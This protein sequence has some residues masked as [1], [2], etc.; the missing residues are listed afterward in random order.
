MFAALAPDYNIEFAR[1]VAAGLTRPRKT[2]SASW[3]YDALGSSLFEAITLLPEYGLT[4]A[5]G[6]LLARH[7][8]EIVKAANSPT[9]VV[10]LGS[11]T[12]T[13]TRHVLTAAARHSHV[14]YV[15]IDISQAALDA[16]VASLDDVDRVR[17]QP[18]TGDYFY[19]L[20][21]AL[22]ER[23]RGEHVLVLFLGS[24]I[25][26]FSS[27]DRNS[28]LQRVRRCL[29]PGDSFLLGT[30]LIKSKE[31]LVRAYD[32]PLGVTAAFNLNLL[33]RMNRELGGTFKIQQFA[34]EARWNERQ[35]RIE[36][37]LRSRIAQTVRIETLRLELKFERDET[38]WTESC[39]KFTAEQVRRLGSRA[40]WAKSEQWLDRDWGFAETLFTA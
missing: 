40:G 22:A 32:D 18:I 11:G 20:E 9:L 2:L 23:R 19:G 15:P 14:R 26:N 27:A 25:G 10:E 31:V 17:V 21:N 38:I 37:H 13:K 30:D 35:S 7:S 28:C 12:G 33:A 29:N 6:R 5:D 1:D 4:R 34:H 8:P 3:L 39:H 16:C 36:M 24:T